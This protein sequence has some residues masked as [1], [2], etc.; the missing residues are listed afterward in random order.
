[1]IAGT[2]NMDW[3]IYTVCIVGVLVLTCLSHLFRS[4]RKQTSPK[5]RLTNDDIDLE[6]VIESPYSGM[7]DEIDEEMLTDDK[8]Y[9]VPHENHSVQESVGDDDTGYLDACVE[10]EEADR[11]TLK[12]K[13]SQERSNSSCSSNSNNAAQD[14]TDYLNPYNLLR[15]NWKED[16]HKYAVS[17]TVNMVSSNAVSDE[18]TT[19]HKYS[20]RYQSPQTNGD[21]KGQAYEKSQTTND[22][23]V[24]Q[25]TLSIYSISR[26]HDYIHNNAESDKA[27]HSYDDEA[28]ITKDNK[29][30]SDQTKSKPTAKDIFRNDFETTENFMLESVNNNVRR[31]DNDNNSLNAYDD[32][33]S[34]N[35]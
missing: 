8:I 23:Q 12:D 13:I 33:K 28:A 20:H 3:M 25:T 2:S 11:Q 1:M 5:D 22:T 9:F 17:V 16:S 18:E 26:L 27:I 19:N 35:S 6:Q 7:Y 21:L 31:Q 30:A 29:R 32:A 24:Q 34:C 10:F 14:D 4:Y 15:E